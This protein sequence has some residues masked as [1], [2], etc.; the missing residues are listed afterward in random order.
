MRKNGCQLAKEIANWKESVAERWDQIQVVEKSVPEIMGTYQT[1]AGQKYPIRIVIDEAGLE[2]AVGL[3]LVTL[4]TDKEGVDHIYSVEP[5][6]VVAQEG[7]RYTFELEQRINN[8]GA[9]KVAYRMFP[10]ND[11]LP[12]RQDICYVRWL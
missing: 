12:H 4:S 11:L 8:A 9:F 1:I 7:S 2:D 10:K 6:K 3:E 5:F